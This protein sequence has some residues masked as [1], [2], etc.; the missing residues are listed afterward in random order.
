MYGYIYKTTCLLNNK[1]YI[2]QRKGDFDKEYLGSGLLINRAIDKYGRD[3][4][5][6]ILIAQA[7]DKNSINILEKYYIGYYKLQLPKE[8]IYNIA[9]GGHGGVTTLGYK[10]SDQ[11]KVKIGLANSNKIPSKE[12]NLKRSIALKGRTRPPFTLEHKMKISQTKRRLH[13]ATYG[14]LGKTQSQETRDKISK[15]QTGVKRGPYKICIQ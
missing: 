9:E 6:V 5:A 13:V 8:L 4:F 3:N 1:I 14:M 12:S 10:H 7:I 15:A 11:T 2:G